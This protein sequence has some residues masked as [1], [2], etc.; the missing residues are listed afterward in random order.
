MQVY[1][2]SERPPSKKIWGVLPPSMAM[3]TNAINAKQ[4]K[5]KTS[6]SRSRS[7]SR[8]RRFRF[9]D[10]GPVH[11]G[12]ARKETKHSSSH[13]KTRNAMQCG[14]TLRCNEWQGHAFAK[15]GVAGGI[16]ICRCRVVVGSKRVFCQ[17]CRPPPRPVADGAVALNP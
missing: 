7:R 11:M 4:Y 1:A 16:R 17:P 5:A 15:P 3:H 9:E 6:S 10:P 2:I 12:I 8:S 14:A 13:A